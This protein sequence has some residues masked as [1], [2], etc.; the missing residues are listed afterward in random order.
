MNEEE[1]KGQCDSV[2][3][4][5]CTEYRFYITGSVGSGKTTALEQIRS[6][7]TF[8]EWV[9]R[10]HPLLGCPHS[11]LTSEQ[12]QEVDN[13]I[14]Q[15]FRKKNRRINAANQ[16]ISIID[17]SPLDPLYF[18]VDKR[19]ISERAKELIYWMVPNQGA[20]K[21][22]A[23]GHIIILKCDPRG[24]RVRLASRAKSYTEA[25]LIPQI[26]IIEETWKG[27]P[28]TVIDTTNMSISQVVSKILETILFCPYE[29]ID[30][31]NLCSSKTGNIA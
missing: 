23:S 25:Q 3:D 22:I 29:S 24:L 15:Q 16:S 9:D 21:Q 10:R 4:G 12:R 8:D 2:L 13:W 17:R 20:V 19:S 30:L 11:E 27:F 7:K 18:V 5:V 1:F 31:H 6:I 26:E 28:V 14:N